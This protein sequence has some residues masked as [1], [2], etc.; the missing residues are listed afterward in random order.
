MNNLTAC[1]LR[2]SQ[3]PFAFPTDRA[4]IECGLETCWQPNR[5]AVRMACIANTLEVEE[6]WVSAPLIEEARKNPHLQV[7]GD[8]VL[9]PFDDGGNLLQEKL[10][11]HSV[12]G[13]R[14][15]ERLSRIWQVIFCPKPLQIG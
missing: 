14:G 10:F 15:S 11:P 5:D 4:C 9:L 13:R 1:F 6:L 8:A 2:R 7:T 3:L 12:R